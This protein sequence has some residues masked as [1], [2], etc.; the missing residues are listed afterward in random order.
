MYPSTTASTHSEQDRPADPKS[1]EILFRELLSVS[2]RIYKCSMRLGNMAGRAFGPVPTT[3]EKV[4]DDSIQQTP[5]MMD[6]LSMAMTQ[7][8]TA[9]NRL[10]SNIE[11]VERIV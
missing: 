8:Q 3:S 6:S 9:I 5:P 1:L 4:G 2:D 11:R 10:E 7:I